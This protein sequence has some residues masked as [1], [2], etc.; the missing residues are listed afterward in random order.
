MHSH[1]T[2]TSCFFPCP[3]LPFNAKKKLKVDPARFI[4]MLNKIYMLVRS[5]AHIKD[6][7]ILFSVSLT[8]GRSY[9]R[10]NVGGVSTTSYKIP[11]VYVSTGQG[12][13]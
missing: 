5:R 4:I 13:I 6:T 12:W 1:S 2:M 9:F 3:K 11:S 7:P 8:Q 10:I